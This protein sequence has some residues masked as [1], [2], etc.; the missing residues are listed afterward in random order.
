M[1]D[2]GDAGAGPRRGVAMSGALVVA[3]PKLAK[4]IPRLSSDKDGEVLGAARAIGRVLASAEADW[5]DLV[6]VLTDPPAVG[7][8]PA[9]DLPFV[10]R[11]LHH[12][13]SLTEWES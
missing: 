9:D 4:L 6:R 2:S 3:A 13:P 1:A 12:H 11:C 10:L 8:D 7:A 5:H